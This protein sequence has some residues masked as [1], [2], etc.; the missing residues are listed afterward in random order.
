MTVDFRTIGKRIKSHRIQRKMT[1]ANLAERI[2]IS[3]VH[4]SYI[5]TGTK[6][7]SLDVLLKIVN[8]FDLSLDSL[9]LEDEPFRLPKAHR[10]LTELLT[11][12]DFDELEQITKIVADYIRMIRVERG[13]SHPA[14]LML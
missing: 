8:E 6:R 3:N 2:G 4:I 13:S 11:S 5:E 10:K 7:V 12:C 14:I 1:Q 9:V